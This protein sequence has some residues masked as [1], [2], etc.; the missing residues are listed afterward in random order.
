MLEKGVRLMIP[1]SAWHTQV[2]SRPEAEE[3]LL[4]LGSAVTKFSKGLCKHR[5][6]K[7][8]SMTRLNQKGVGLVVQK[9]TTCSD[10]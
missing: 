4:P 2:S 8:S 9:C 7:P 6:T 1:P 10:T 3:H 5:K